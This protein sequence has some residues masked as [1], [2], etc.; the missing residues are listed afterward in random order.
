[1]RGNSAFAGF[2]R[3]GSEMVMSAEEARTPRNVTPMQSVRNVRTL[4]AACSLSS[5]LAFTPNSAF[6]RWLGLGVAL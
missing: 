4:Q 6:S 2:S 1:M 5:I 3:V